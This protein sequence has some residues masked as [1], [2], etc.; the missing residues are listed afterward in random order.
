MPPASSLETIRTLKAAIPAH[1]ALAELRG[2]GDLIP[3]Q[4]MLIRAILLQEA[5]LSSEVENIVTTNDAMYKAL[6]DDVKPTDPNTKEVLRYGEALW[7]GYAALRSGRP[8]SAGM[9]VELVQV[10]KKVELGIRTLPGC[11]VVNQA[12]GEPVYT[13]PEG[14]DRIRRF[15]DNLSEYIYATDDLDPLIKMAVVHYQFEAIHPFPDGNGRTGRVVNLL[16]LLEKELLS[17]PILYLSRFIIEHKPDY[18]ATLRAV[19]ESEAWEEWIVYMLQAVE[20]TALFT[21][22]MIR[23]IRIA[24][25]EAVVLARQNMGRAYSKELVELVFAQPYTRIASVVRAGL[26]KRQT[27]SEHLRELERIGLL[28]S[29]KLGSEMLYLNTRLMRILTA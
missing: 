9:Y 8:L 1:T 5:R 15:L 6:S 19:T 24:L 3:N 22:D 11:Q 25:D 14:E 23:Q 7:H 26:A 12:T 18:Y 4:S 10:I 21:R 27:A 13:P 28:R 2:V 20:H 29:V 16:F 17:L